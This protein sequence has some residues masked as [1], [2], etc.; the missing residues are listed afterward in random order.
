MGKALE[1]RGSVTLLFHYTLIIMFFYT[2][3]AAT[4]LSAYFVSRRK[5]FL[6]ATLGFT[7]YFFDV[8]LVFK[9][10]FI[11][12]A[13]VFDAPSFYDVGNPEATIFTGAGT[14]LFLWLAACRYCR[15][16]R[17]AIRYL[18]VVFWV[19]ASLLSFELVPDHQWR[20]FIFY[21]MRAVLLFFCYGVLAYWYRHAP[22]EQRRSIMRVHRIAFYWAVGLTALVVAEN[23]YVQLIFDPSVLPS[24][25]WLMAER[26]PAENLLFICFGVVVVHGAA[27]C[28]RLRSQ[29]AP[30]GDDPLLEESIDRLLPLYTRD[31]DLSKRE[32]E[33]L[34]LA[35]MGLDNQNIASSLTLTAGTVKVHMH[36]I[37]KKTGRANRAELADDFWQ[38]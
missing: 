37:L 8:S 14:F 36:N 7:F 19:V 18:P 1:A 24:D 35:L 6:Y 30:E 38:R 5:T 22:N 34:R 28:L 4:S 17:F 32:T 16:D 10:N 23:V 12:P 31:H 2:I 3:V 13:A 11:T 25:M 21:S 26:S 15:E 33:V 27:V 29:A 9:D 20:E